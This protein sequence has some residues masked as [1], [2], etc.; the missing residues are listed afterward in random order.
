MARFGRRL[1]FL[2]AIL[3]ALVG[4]GLTLLAVYESLYWLLIIGAVLQVGASCCRAQA[5]ARQRACSGRW[6]TGRLGA[7]HILLPQP[8]IQAHM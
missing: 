1:V 3:L 6:Q 7:A 2:S 8:P 4:A 5:D